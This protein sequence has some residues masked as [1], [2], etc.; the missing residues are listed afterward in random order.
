MERQSLLTTLSL[1]L[2]VPP[3]LRLSVSPSDFM[4]SLTHI[5]LRNWHRFD[6]KMIEVEDS[7]YLAGANGTGKSSVLDAMQ[8][9]LIAELQK[10]RFNSSAQQGQERSERSLDTYVRGKIGEDRWLRPGNTVAYIALEFTDKT[11]GSKLTIGACIEAGEGKGSSGERMYFILS[12][13]IDPGL[14]L[15]DGRELTRRELKQALKNRQG[16]RSY[17]HVNEYVEQML[18]RLGGLNPRFPDLFLRALAFQPIRQIG[19]FVEKWLLQEKR[20]DTETLRQVKERLDQLRVASREVRE[21]LDALRAII[22]RQAEVRRLRD[23]RAEYTVLTALLRVVEIERRIKTLT[24]QIS[25]TEGRIGEAQV[26][27]ANIQSSLAGAREALFQAR[28]QLEQS[29]VIRRRDELQRQLREAER[30]AREIEQ[31]WITLLGDLRRESKALR[32]LLESEALEPAEA[33]PLREMIEAI[34]GLTDDRPPLDRLPQ[35][36]DETLPPLESALNRAQEA[37]FKIRQQSDELVK[38]GHGLEQELE[39]LRSTGR[40]AYRREVERL[41]DLLEPALGA[42]PPLLCELLEIPDQRWQDAVEAMLGARRFTIIVPPRDFD[43]ALKTLDEARAREQ[44]YEAALLDLGR[45]RDEARQARPGSLASQ[46][47]TPN[48]GEGAALRAY[49]DSVLGDIITC[50]ETGQLRSHRRA[51]TP[52]VVY[53]GEWTVRAIRPD[54]Y[55]PWFIGA[56]AQRSQIEA[57]ER[58]LEEI[59]ERLL[60]LQPQSSMIEARVAALRRVYELGR[61]RQR[62]DAPLDARGLRGLINELGA[63]LQSLDLSGVAALQEEVNRLQSLVERNETAKE[64]ISERL[65]E[66]KVGLQ[67][68][69]QRKLSAMREHGEAG[70]QADETRARY[71][72]A[73]IT[74]EELMDERLGSIDG[75]ADSQNALDDIIR[76]AENRAKAFETQAYNEQQRLTEE[77]TKYNTIYQ[78]AGDAFDP[79]SNSYLNEER[80]LDATELPKY[81]QQIAE[82]QQRADQQLREHVLHQLRENILTAQQELDR[83]NDALRDLEFHHKRYRFTHKPNDK[84]RSYYDLILGTELLGSEPLFE[85]LFYQQHKDSFDDFYRQLTAPGGDGELERLTDYRQYLSYDI[86]VLHGDGQRSQL[87]K[88]MGHTSGGETQTPFYLTIAASF[89][90]LYRVG[91]GSPA[92]NG[93]QRTGQRVNRGQ[94]PTVRLVAFD[95][96]FSKMDQQHIG[97]TLD[98]F[99]KFNLQVITATPLERC[100]Y[101]V[102]KMCTSLVLTAVGDSVLI[103]PYRNYA[104]RLR[105]APESGKAPEEVVEESKAYAD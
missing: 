102:P 17:D 10:I 94:R 80:R 85:S 7:L 88:I 62:F 99:Q 1:H 67:S 34:A 69:G 58:E 41:R 98:L 33:P 73:I 15:R 57:R 48:E 105:R 90:Q 45:A 53:Y 40:A 78:F 76:N 55:R 47:E 75:R 16:A 64:R 61:L 71:P 91:E 5:F 32:P 52:N 77:A 21:K 63:E 36:I 23:R 9:V 24:G 8:V 72:E 4:L 22:E 43:A 27:S 103:E 13:A 79:L 18:D 42:R 2:S 25:E 81:E 92:T 50:E 6:H 68:L 95:E 44:L 3:S 14:F 54:N 35:L 66:L 82:E 87:S 30:Q 20:L 84:R 60:E 56:R 83:I 29:G 100:E 89:L 46:V 39:R 49:I 19:E 31:R 70:Q 11:R 37:Q 59:R 101:L 65:T 26:E 38:R 86:E 104:A 97:S 28:M 96:A 74:A 12:E 93:S 51:V